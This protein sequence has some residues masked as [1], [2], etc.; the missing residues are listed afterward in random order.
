MPALT[1]IQPL[2][3]VNRFPSILAQRLVSLLDQGGYEVSLEDAFSIWDHHTT[4][5]NP[6]AISNAKSSEDVAQIFL[7][8]A[9][10]AL[11]VLHVDQVRLI[12]STA[13]KRTKI[14]DCQVMVQRMRAMGYE[15]SV[16]DALLVWTAYSAYDDSERLNNRGKAKWCTHVDDAKLIVIFDTYTDMPL[17]PATKA[18]IVAG[19]ETA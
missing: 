9:T 4:K 7:L 18:G 19:V 13:V 5:P 1:R 16:M 11:G 10:R 12:P 8:Y 17:L 14:A 6:A 15:I 2:V 3:E